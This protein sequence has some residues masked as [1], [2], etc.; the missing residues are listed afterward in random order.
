M[1]YW[2]FDSYYSESVPNQSQYFADHEQKKGNGQG[3]EI[4]T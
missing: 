2:R 4:K 3:D 1:G